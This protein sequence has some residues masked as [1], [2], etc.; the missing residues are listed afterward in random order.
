ML[1]RAGRIA[2]AAGMAVMAAGAAPP[3]RPDVPVMVGGMPDLDAC[4]TNS[5]VAGLDP[6]GDNYVSLRSRP[7]ASAPEL[8]RLGPGQMVWACDTSPDGKW[9]G[10]VFGPPGRDLD[11]GVGTPIERRQPYG[12]SC[13]SGWISGRYLV[14][15][16]G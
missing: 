5:Q 16:A 9:V 14:V 3:P 1:R 6:E 13:A 11:C 8:A 7:A 4:M 10:V 15:I 2:L 12:G